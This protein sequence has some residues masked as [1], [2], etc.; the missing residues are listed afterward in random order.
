MALTG[1]CACG[2]VGYTIHKDQK[3]VGPCH[4]DTCRKWTGGVFLG[5]QAGADEATLTGEEH[6]TIWKSSDW[7]ER[8]FCSKCGSS[9]FY[10]LTIPGPMHGEYHFGAGALEDWGDLKM[11]GEIFIDKKPDAYEFAGDHP[12]L[13]T[14]EFLASIAPPPDSAP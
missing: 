12:R 8:A 11:V 6:L 7:A 2:A 5:V 9:L 10:R 14:E 13:T 4:C 1:K 3:E